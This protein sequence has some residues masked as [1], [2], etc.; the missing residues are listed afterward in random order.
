[1]TTSLTLRTVK[2]SELTW[3]ELDAN[4]TALRTTADAALP[5]A[6]GSI[7]STP[8]GA[9]T[10]STGAFTTLSASGNASFGTTGAVGVVKLARY[11]DGAYVSELRLNGTGAAPALELYNG[12]ASATN[13]YSAGAVAGSFSST[14]L[15]VTGALS[16]TNGASI[17]GASQAANTLTFTYSAIQAGTIGINSSGAMVFGL[18]GSTGTTTRATISTDGNLGL[19]VTPSAWYAT[20]T[21]ALQVGASSSVNDFSASGNRQTTVANN[22]YLNA[23]AAWTYSNTDPASRHHQTGGQHIW[24]TAPSGT[25]GDPITFTQSLAVGKGTTLAL[26]GATSAAGTGIAFP[27]TQL[28]SS[29]ANTLDDYREATYTATATG[30]TT[31]PTGTVSF[32][33]VGNLVTLEIPVITGTS[34]ATTFTLT[35]GPTTMRPSA[36]RSF[37]FN[38]SDNSGTNVFGRAVLD[39]GGTITLFTTAGSGA[40]TASG[41]KATTAINISYII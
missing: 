4:F 20:N 1:M 3:G 21:K 34:N 26:E 35:G 10:P 7:N 25:A 38:G 15:A 11:T 22:A 12:V 17:T 6:G 40:W 23:S 8:I 31:S 41:T 33:R 24:Y 30:M 36:S 9:T 5:A 32:V 29:N 2:G 27:A 37:V 19:G 28:A 16:A 18:D 13:I 14:G 39:T